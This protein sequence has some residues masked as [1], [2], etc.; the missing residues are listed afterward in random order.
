M[1]RWNGDEEIAGDCAASSS[2]RFGK[3]DGEGET[4]WD[5]GLAAEARCDRDLGQVGRCGLAGMSVGVSM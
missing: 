2:C 1:Y 3:K 5:M 4:A